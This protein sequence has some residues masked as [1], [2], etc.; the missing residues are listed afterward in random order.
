[1]MPGRT[2]RVRL[3]AIAVCLVFVYFLYWNKGYERAADYV[4][5]SKVGGGAVLRKPDGKETEAVSGPQ[6]DNKIEHLPKPEFEPKATSAEALDA[7]PATTPVKVVEPE[8]TT[9]PAEAASTS[10][11]D[12]EEWTPTKSLP[13]LPP[14]SSTHDDGT[15]PVNVGGSHVYQAPDA[16]QGNVDAYGNPIY[17]APEIHW[18]KQP[19]KWPITSTI[20]L[21]S[22]TPKPIPLVQKKAS[23]GADAQRL[24]AVKEACKHAWSGYRKYGWGY[25]EV[26][27]VS[28]VG[29]NSFNGWGATLVDSLDTLWIMGMKDEFEDAV[30]QTKYIDFT[31]S[32]RNDIPLFEVTI[33]YLGGLV[34]AYD[35]SGRKYRALLDKA[36]EL[37]EILYSAFDTPNRMPETYY[38]WKPTFASNGHRASTRVVMAELGTLSLEFTR[39]AQLT[40][41]PKYYDAVARITDAF[42]EWQNQT[43]IPGMWPTMVDASGCAKPVQLPPSTPTWNQLPVPGG[44]SYMVSSEPVQV[45]SEVMD[46]AEATLNQQK[47]QSGQAARAGS[48]D[49]S[50]VNAA[51]EKS[52]SDE[53]RWTDGTPVTKHRKRQLHVGDLVDGTVNPRVGQPA[54]D[55]APAK[56]QTGP[57]NVN[58]G[59]AAPNG[60]PTYVQQGYNPSQPY[61]PV[62][63]APKE[64]ECIPQGL[65]STSSRG[66]ESFT[67]GGQSDSTYEYLPKMHLLIGG[68]FDQYKNM[69]LAS[70]IPWTEKGLFRP[71]TPDNLDILISG[72]VVSA[73]NYTDRTYYEVRHSK[74]EHLTCFAG[75]MF[76]MGGKLFGMPEHVEIGRKLTDGC[77][78]AYNATT[79]GIMPEGFIAFACP[80]K[81]RCEWNE[82]LYWEELDPY[83][84]YRDEQRKEYAETYGED[85]L[86]ANSRPT[87]SPSATSSSSY[88]LSRHRP[89][90][91]VKE[92][93]FEEDYGA[94]NKP[95]TAAQDTSQ[96]NKR[97]LHEENV[98]DDKLPPLPQAAHSPS[99]VKAPS[100]KA[101][102]GPGAG[103]EDVIFSANSNQ[104]GAN[105]QY[106]SVAYPPSPSPVEVVAPV[107]TPPPPPTHKQYV[108]QKIEDERLAPGFVRYESTK[109]ILRP[110]AIESVFYMY[111][112]TGEQYWRDMGWKMFQAVDKHTR[113]Q[114]GHSALDDITKLHPEQLDGMES[115]WIA[116]TLKY[117]YLLFDAPD[118]WSLDDWVMNTEAHFFKRPEN[119]IGN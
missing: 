2:R 47:A 53:L 62:Y 11:S 110:E 46:K 76:A 28:G 68:Q 60:A 98:A 50:G 14:A 25:D 115:F 27:P 37:A 59:A 13:T 18:T 45:D 51:S 10:G 116:E 40:K 106:D 54:A 66:M 114:F 4:R 113:A 15:V 55:G 8:A 12:A 65:R 49:A 52:S 111:R 23:K 91:T 16:G 29:K 34:G 92:D 109:Y 41:E 70:M 20:Q 80:D 42:E 48:L 74:G 26:E 44:D 9:A 61:V 39:L 95:A 1:M 101:N 63:E 3:L 69:Y 19:E 71:M 30:N 86:I 77:I 89:G 75:G 33:R 105:T 85:A 78:W 57:Q 107:Y 21:P 99:P 96:Y 5:P 38:Y 102:Y 97:Q 24:A 43:R 6:L 31:T 82:T 22:G 7:V 79:T 118:T 72:E 84:S 94:N 104:Y 108:E 58:Q 100:D 36:V 90:Q 119:P 103:G 93:N 64:P 87:V 67:L 81:N 112:I 88:T 117:F 35:V 83:Q 73:W 17:S 56:V 32:S